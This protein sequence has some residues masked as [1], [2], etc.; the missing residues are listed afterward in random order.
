MQ[1]LAT[2]LQSGL[3]DILQ[4]E[5]EDDSG[6]IAEQRLWCAVILSVFHEYEEWLMR[7]ERQW[8][9]TQ[10]PVNCSYRFTLEAMRREC[11]H[12]WFKHVCGLADI[13]HGRVMRKL[14]E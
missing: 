9:T 5:P 8:K 6:V 3:M 7:A 1:L 11:R 12:V 10:R 14:D 2:A 13:A 4:L